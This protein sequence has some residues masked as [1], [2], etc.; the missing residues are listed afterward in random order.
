MTFDKLTRLA[1]LGEKQNEQASD[2]E[3]R[4]YKGNITYQEANQ[5][6]NQLLKDTREQTATIAA[7]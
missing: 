6:L 7:L 4:L 2:I 3:Q 5:R 1:A